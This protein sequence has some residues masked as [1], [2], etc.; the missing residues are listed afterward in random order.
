V[1]FN[2]AADNLNEVLGGIVGAIDV[3][4]ASAEE[5]ASASRDL[6]RQ[7]ARPRASRKPRQPSSR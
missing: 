4:G 6:S 5:I 3:V 7:R 1:D 2:V